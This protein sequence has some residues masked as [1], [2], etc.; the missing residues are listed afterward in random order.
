MARIRS[1]DTKPELRVR[2]LVHGL[3]YRYRLHD[4]KL[5]G[6]PDLVFR[7]RKKVIFVHGC[8]WHQHSASNCR[9]VHAPKS[10]TEYWNPKLRRNVERDTENIASLV[11]KGWKVFVVW[12]CAVKNAVSLTRELVEFL[13]DERSHDRTG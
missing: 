13:D 12:E 5:P 10:S 8:F 6:K 1:T 7:S 3:G 4:P 11:A 9:V 2:R